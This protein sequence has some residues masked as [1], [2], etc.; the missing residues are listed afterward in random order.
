MHARLKFI[1]CNPVCTFSIGS[2]YIPLFIVGAI[3]W[4]TERKANAITVL[5][6]KQQLHLATLHII[7]VVLADSA[8]ILT[9]LPHDYSGSDANSS[10]RLKL[11]A[12]VE[13][14]KQSLG[15]KT[16]H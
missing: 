16:E 11:N 1:S 7:A 9:I 8:S 6:M 5:K 15:K 2:T 3:N 13:T 4:L 14:I 12:V 10:A